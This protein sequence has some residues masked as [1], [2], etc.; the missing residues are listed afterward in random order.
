MSRLTL[1]NSS[2]INAVNVNYTYTN[3]GDIQVKTEARQGRNGITKMVPVGLVVE[4][5]EMSVSNRFW[6]SI[7]SRYG[8]SSSIFKY[9]GYGEVF[10]RIAEVSSKDTLRVCVQ[11]KEGKKTALAVSNPAAPIVDYR[12]GFELFKDYDAEQIVY[13][14]GIITTIHTPRVGDSGAINGDVFHN[15]FSI[16]TPI[17]GY[18][19]P[20]IYLALLRQVCSNGLVAMSTAFKTSISFGKKDDSFRHQL[21][22]V[23]EGFNSDEGYAAIRDRIQAASNSPASVY[24]VNSL[25]KLMAR[26]I[27][28]TAEEQLENNPDLTE[29]SVW[30]NQ[31]GTR[32]EIMKKYLNL[33]GDIA[34]LYGLANT[35]ALS[36]KRQ[37]TLNA[38]CTVYDL[39]NFATEVATHHIP[40][41]KRTPID[42]WVGT[43]IT[44]EYDLEGA[45]SL[46]EKNTTSDLYL[47]N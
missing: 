6:D 18:G 34:L 33:T 47:A 16:N 42:G 3:V 17:D 32:G 13:D 8:F 39:I 9:F 38:K 30:K 24:E 14:N 41:E 36:E 23:I 44:K 37:R 21:I 22:R 10:S 1:K 31:E 4:D 12:E 40:T 29:V 28:N 20:N 27:S 15:K 25:Y 43:L 5:E 45:K 26:H 35:D 2:D 7:M 19:T 46:I 11:E